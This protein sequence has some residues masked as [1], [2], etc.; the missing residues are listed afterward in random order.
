MLQQEIKR[1][2][3][4]TGCLSL[5]LLPKIDEMFSKLQ[6]AAISSTIDLRSGYYHIGL[7]RE[8]RAKSAFLVPMGKWQF[9]RTPFGL[10]QAPAYFQLLIDKVLMGC[11]D[12]AMGYLDD[13]IIFSKNEEDHL[14]HL[15]EIFSRLQH[16]G[17]KMK[18]EKCAFFKQH[19][20]YLGHLISKAG[21]EP[22]TEKLES[23]GNMPAPKSPKEVKQFLGLIGYYRKFVPHFSDMSRPLTCLTWHDVKFEWMEKCQKSFNRLWEILME[24]LI[25]RYPDP[26]KP[27][28]LY[29]DVSRI[30]WSGVLMQEEMDEKGRSKSHPICYISG[31][32]RGS[33][34]NWATLTKEAYAIYMSIRRLM[35]YLMDAEITIKCDHLPLKRFLNKQTLNSKV[36]N[37]A[38]ELEQFNLKLEW[39]QGSKNTLAD[40]LSHLLE[41][42]PEAEL[43]PEQEGQEFG[44]YCFED[45]APVCME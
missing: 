6:G 1:T 3:K 31:Q 22:L 34:L 35:F 44:C 4:G 8:L 32:F 12:F 45:L 37:W 17:L 42:V 11:A 36:N 25:L 21:F 27:Y 28:T 40:S 29:T 16:F 24:Y 10:S 9:K 14:H 23:I 26:L 38:V 7:M 41:V 15:T 13:I 20:Q 2:D 43:E 30:G 33:Q 39:I 19:I 18:R 5:Y